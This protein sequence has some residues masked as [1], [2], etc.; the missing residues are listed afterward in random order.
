MSKRT[1]DYP[2]CKRKPHAKGLC[3]SHYE[4]QRRG[5]P[6]T[7]LQTR[8]EEL[9][10][11]LVNQPP[12]QCVLVGWAPTKSHPLVTLAR[13]PMSVGAAALIL[14]GQPKPSPDHECCHAPL[15]CNNG[16]CVQLDHIR[17]GTRTDNQVDRV[18]DGTH[19]RGERCAAAKLTKSDV[20][21]IRDLCTNS[22]L[23]QHEIADR[24]GIDQ[25]TVSNIKRRQRW[26]HLA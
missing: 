9:Q 3:N 1:C 21:T 18:A 11:L 25:S 17:W 16:R 13:V 20:H 5:R 2:D 4:Q 24:Y 8:L 6:L 15:V 19:N 14:S 22:G 12:G 26:S 23:T 10:L 7:S